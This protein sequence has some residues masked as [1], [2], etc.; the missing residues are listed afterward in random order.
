M[1]DPTSPSDKAAAYRG[2]ILG[3]IAIFILLFS[4]VKLTNAKYD[5]M[6]GATQGQVK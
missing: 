1:S 6:E 4:I 3:V 5:R 2:L